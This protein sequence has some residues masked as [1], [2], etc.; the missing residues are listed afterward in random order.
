MSS[1]GN[2]LL[3]QATARL[4]IRPIMS[5]FSG[6]SPSPVGRQP[7]SVTH[8]TATTFSSTMRQEPASR[9]RTSCLR[10]ELAPNFCMNVAMRR[11]APSDST[12]RPST[13]ESGT[14]PV[15][16]CSRRCSSHAALPAESVGATKVDEYSARRHRLRGS[17]RPAPSSRRL[18]PVNGPRCR[19]IG[20]RTAARARQPLRPAC[21]RRLRGGN[22]QC[23]G[24]IGLR[25]ALGH[26]Q[27]R[28]AAS[29]QIGLVG[30]DAHSRRAAATARP[31]AEHSSRRAATRRARRRIETSC[32]RKGSS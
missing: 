10:S 24:A 16:T 15:A 25:H 6:R 17:P 28:I 30:I 18:L 12:L 21:S 14:G 13:I 7:D 22:R 8:L 11:S 3:A 26:A 5:S 19:W 23:R 20:N 32:S 27:R 31:Q 2:R 29:A 1:A 4:Q 9:T